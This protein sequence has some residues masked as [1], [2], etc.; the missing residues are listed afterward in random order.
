MFP[1]L[2]V[3]FPAFFVALVFLLMPAVAT[4]PIVASVGGVDEYLVDALAAQ[5]ALHH[6]VLVLIVEG[7][8]VV[9]LADDV[10][11]A[12]AHVLESDLLRALVLL[13]VA[14]SSRDRGDGRA[15]LDACVGAECVAGGKCVAEVAGVC[16]V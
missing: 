7:E 4:V 6:V 14:L 5:H 1:A 9:V 11:A 3:V 2:V 8:A 15:A 13:D 16:C 10:A 12:L